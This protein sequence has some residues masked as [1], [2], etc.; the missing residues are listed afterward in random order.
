[1]DKNWEADTFWK[2]TGKIE[3]SWSKETGVF[4]RKAEVVIDWEKTMERCLLRIAELNDEIE[5][6]EAIIEGQQD[7]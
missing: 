7:D 2:A 1:M 5:R 6:L 3:H 4:D